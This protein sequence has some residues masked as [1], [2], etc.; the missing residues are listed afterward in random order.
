MTRNLLD[1]A[2]RHARSQVVIALHVDAESNM[3]ELT[4]DDDGP[5]IPSED[6]ERVFARFT[7]LDEGRARDAGG[8]GLGLSMVQTIVERHG[9]TVA[10]DDAPL[11][12]ARLTVRLPAV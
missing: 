10:I 5:G 7:R 6:R 9:G 3:V 4:L 11:G 12:G 8:L 1:N 2:L